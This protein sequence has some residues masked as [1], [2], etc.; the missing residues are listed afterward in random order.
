MK[1]KVTCMLHDTLL[2]QHRKGGNTTCSWFSVPVWLIL[3]RNKW[4]LKDNGRTGGWMKG[5]MNCKEI[6]IQPFQKRSLCTLQTLDEELAKSSL[7]FAR[8]QLWN[9]WPWQND[10]SAPLIVFLASDAI[11]PCNATVPPPSG[12]HWTCTRCNGGEQQVNNR[13]T[14]EPVKATRAHSDC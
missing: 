2:M 13:S 7:H 1:C 12:W 14:A 3:I 6:W 9:V 5:R 8:R 4:R 11:L 10:R